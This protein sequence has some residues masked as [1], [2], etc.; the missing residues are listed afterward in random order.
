MPGLTGTCTRVPRL[1]F[2]HSSPQLIALCTSV[3]CSGQATSCIFANRYICPETV[4]IFA[5]INIMP[6]VQL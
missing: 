1:L 5:G 6:Y 3:T 4:A 2:V